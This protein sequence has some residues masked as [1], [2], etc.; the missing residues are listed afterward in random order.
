LEAEGAEFGASGA[1]VGVSA[2]A[3]ALMQQ[4]ASANT[5]IRAF[6]RIHPVFV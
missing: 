4:S 1:S 5:T 6:I 3:I 2:N